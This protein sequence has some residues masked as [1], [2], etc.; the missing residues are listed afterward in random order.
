MNEV[1]L[2]LGH[3]EKAEIEPSV[4]CGVWKPQIEILIREK[5][6]F[7][8]VDTADCVV[9]DAVFRKMPEM[10]KKTHPQIANH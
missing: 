3:L 9:P 7:C 10:T 5:S 6:I 8:R 1:A 4:K 2:L